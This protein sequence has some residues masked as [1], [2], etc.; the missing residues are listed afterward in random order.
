MKDFELIKKAISAKSKSFSPYS[1]F[2][3]GAALLTN[4]N[5]II[6]GANIESASYGLTI[7][8][9]RVAIFSAIMKK[10][11][12]L[13]I[14]IA[15]DSEDFCPPCGACRQ[16]MSEHMDENSKVILINSKLETKSFDL[17]ELLPF[18]F[19]DKILNKK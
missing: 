10:E 18:S 14:A 11:K 5:K 17:K 15:T 1:N 8:A 7:C 4:K 19:N 2:R 3:V 12:I 9:E 13:K 6:E 16:I